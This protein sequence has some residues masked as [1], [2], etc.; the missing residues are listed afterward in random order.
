MNYRHLLSHSLSS[1]WI[2]IAA[3]TADLYMLGHYFARHF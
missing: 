3:G 1:F 2:L